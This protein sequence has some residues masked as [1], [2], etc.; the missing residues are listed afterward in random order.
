VLAAAGARDVDHELVSVD[1]GG[2]EAPADWDSLSTPETYVGYDRTE[3]FAS[4]GGVFPDERRRYTAPAPLTFNH[5]A[6]AGDWTIGSEAAVSSEADGRIV[7]RFQARDLH[8]VMGPVDTGASV[9]FRVLIDGHPPGASH[10]IDV[11]DDGFGSASERRLFQLVRQRG[12]IDEH[13][14]E[15]AFLDPGIAA[16]VFTFG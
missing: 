4:P 14:V 13:T 5:W 3:S 1:A 7:F 8:L 15:I 16:Y 2:D 12:A 9:R 10:G 11:D 6:L